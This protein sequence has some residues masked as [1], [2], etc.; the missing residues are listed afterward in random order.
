MNAR[1]ALTVLL[2]VFCVGVSAFSQSFLKKDFT[3]W[4]E[5]D[6]RKLITDSPWTQKFTI[7]QV[8]MEST[9]T[10]GS[11]RGREQNPQIEYLVQFRSA[12]PVR[13]AMVRLAQI[14]AGYDRLAPEGRKQFDEQTRRFLEGAQG[15]SVVVHV[16]FTTNVQVDE[17]EL[18]RYWHSKTTESLRNFVF[19][20][21][22]GGKKT[23][24]TSYLAGEGA[25]RAFQFQF[26]RQ[27]DGQ[28]VIGPKDKTLAIEFVHPNIRN[29]GE[30]RVYVPFKV[31][32]MTI[33]GEVFY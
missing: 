17:R 16:T 13:R 10:A 1:S 2:S 4:S 22:A 5:Y 12:L 21:G 29:Q 19:L 6:C 24:L 9:S 11:E 20:I 30:Q 15:N 7:S 32:K 25:S 28:P 27:V 23:E 3:Q 33:D 14:Q 8:L 31:D 26:P 18:L